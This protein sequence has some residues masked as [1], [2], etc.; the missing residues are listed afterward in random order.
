MRHVSGV[1]GHSSSRAPIGGIPGAPVA[2]RQL[3]VRGGWSSLRGS[4]Q[5][6]TE[7]WLRTVVEGVAVFGVGVV[8]QAFVRVVVGAR[9]VGRRAF[10]R[11]WRV[12]L[13][14]AGGAGCGSG[15]IAPGRG[16]AGVGR[17]GLVGRTGPVGSWRCRRDRRG[18][19]HAQ[20][21]GHLQHPAHGGLWVADPHLASGVEGGVAHGDERA[22]SG[23]VQRKRLTGASASSAADPTGQRTPLVAQAP[24]VDAAGGIGRVRG[25]DWG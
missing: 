1:R 11:L 15:P 10:G 24:A 21:P 16:G 17:T 18:G 13:C 22:D 20:Q 5:S 14:W 19:D 12:L 9:V 2:G 3:T 8:V 23:A 7:T 25:V 4:V 6:G